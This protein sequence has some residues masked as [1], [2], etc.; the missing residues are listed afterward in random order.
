M[1]GDAKRFVFDLETPDFLGFPG[2]WPVVAQIL[3][4][5]L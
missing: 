5:T 3:K 1:Y 2:P 4:V